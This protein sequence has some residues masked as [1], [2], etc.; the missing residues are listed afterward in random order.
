MTVLQHVLGA[1][2]ERD[3]LL[4]EQ[5]EIHEREQEGNLKHSE[6]ATN[7]N[8]LHEIFERLVAIEADKAESKAIRILIGLGFSQEELH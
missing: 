3:R 7:S 1:D 4:K 5:A 6:S 2:V 8:R